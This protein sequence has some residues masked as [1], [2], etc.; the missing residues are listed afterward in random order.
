MGRP[1]NGYYDITR[2][3]FVSVILEKS[4][5][6]ITIVFI[7]ISPYSLPAYSAMR[8]FDKVVDISIFSE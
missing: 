1:R 7:S 2:D 4:K 3:R 8:H 5:K 6:I